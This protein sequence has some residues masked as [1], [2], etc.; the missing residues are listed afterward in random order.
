MRSCATV[1]TCTFPTLLVWILP[2]LDMSAGV[3]CLF[4]TGVKLMGLFEEVRGEEQSFLQM[5]A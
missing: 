3:R 2:S 5:E 1:R 4:I